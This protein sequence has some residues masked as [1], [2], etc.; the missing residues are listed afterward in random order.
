MGSSAIGSGGPAVRSRRE[1]ASSDDFGCMTG[2][3]SNPQLL[4]WQ[5]FSGLTW[6]ADVR[7]AR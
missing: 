5:M 1:S 7:S 2:F 4:K 6:K 3:G